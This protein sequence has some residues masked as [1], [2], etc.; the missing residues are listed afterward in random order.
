MFVSLSILYLWKSYNYRQINTVAV[1]KIPRRSFCFDS[2]PLL[3]PFSNLVVR[4]DWKW[5]LVSGGSL[6][7]KM[8]EVSYGVI[9]QSWSGISLSHSNTNIYHD[10]VIKWKHIPRY[11]PFDISPVTGEFPTQRPVTRSF[12]VFFSKLGLNERLSKQSWGWW[13][14][15]PIMTSQ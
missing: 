12:D 9:L 15:T 13:F 11:W 8:W 7:D 1:T 14:E 6:F 5:R 4:A 2:R 10:D 3:I